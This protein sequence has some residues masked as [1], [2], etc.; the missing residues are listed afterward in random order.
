MPK[1]VKKS[2]KVTSYKRHAPRPNSG[3]PQHHK[4]CPTIAQ[5]R[6]EFARHGHT[7]PTSAHIRAARSHIKK[8][9]GWGD[10]IAAVLRKVGPSVVRGVGKLATKIP[11][12]IRGTSG[13]ARAV[14]SKIPNVVASRIPGTMAN[15]ERK[16]TQELAQRA[17]SRM[18]F[19]PN[20]EAFENQAKL[21][22]FNANKKLPAGMKDTRNEVFNK[23]LPFRIQSAVDKIA[24]PGVKPP[25]RI[26]PSLANTLPPQMDSLAGIKNAFDPKKNA[27]KKASGRHKSTRIRLHK[28][29]GGIITKT[30]TNKFTLLSHKGKSLGTYSSMA[31][32]QARERQVNYFKHL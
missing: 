4:P 10:A 15:M 13:A 31:G 11:A 2:V 19:Q 3:L 16:A 29:K 14:A 7:K 26:P 21:I 9:A 25:P 17:I 6:A 27:L 18:K 12:I 1:T 28:P 8:G 32:A 24:T 23:G 22:K 30:G 20:R 5:I